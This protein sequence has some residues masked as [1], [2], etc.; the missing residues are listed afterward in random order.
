MGG[1]SLCS[2]LRAALA[3]LFIHERTL[4]LRGNWQKAMLLTAAACSPKAP[5]TTRTNCHKKA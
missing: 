3:L 4:G 5:R 2:M 1:K